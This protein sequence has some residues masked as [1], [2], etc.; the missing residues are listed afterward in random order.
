MVDGFGNV[1]DQQGQVGAAAEE[2]T[3]IGHLA[4]VPV[5]LAPVHADLLGDHA[6][7]SFP[8]SDGLDLGI[9]LSNDTHLAHPLQIGR[10]GEFQVGDGVAV[11]HTAVFIPLAG[12]VDI[13]D[14]GDGT[15]AL[16][17]EGEAE[18]FGIHGA[19][20]L[21]Q[22]FPVDILGADGVGA[23]VGLLQVAA[24]LADGAVSHLVIAG[25]T[26]KFAPELVPHGL[27]VFQ[28]GIGSHRLTHEVHT[29][30]Q[31]TGSFQICQY[32]SEAIEAV[33]AHFLHGGDAPAVHH[34]HVLLKFGNDEIPVPQNIGQ[35]T[36][37]GLGIAGF[38]GKLILVQGCLVHPAGLAAC[39]KQ[40][41]RTVAEGGIQGSG[42]VDGNSLCIPAMAQNALFGGDGGGIGQSGLYQFRFAGAGAEIGTHKTNGVA[43]KEAVDVGKAG[44]DG[45]VAQ[46]INSGIRTDQ[47]IIGSALADAEDLTVSNGDEAGKGLFACSGKNAVGFQQNV[48][49]FG[50]NK[51]TPNMVAA[52]CGSP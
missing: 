27:A 44:A 1:V 50:H 39:G 43:G 4:A 35:Q 26:D 11:Y 23:V 5:V 19:G 45:T 33:E 6:E 36:H 46:I 32:V 17:M 34:F 18:A 29:Q 10:I 22:L 47:S 51:F 24:Q 3:G 31:I 40:D 15:V 13:Q 12:L 41:G 52:F 25:E 14:L 16:S 28:V 38:G 9:D 20:F 49:K 8:V 30:R 21:A 2:D 7:L 42:S 37:I 48:C